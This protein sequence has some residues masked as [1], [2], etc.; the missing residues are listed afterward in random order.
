[1]VVAAKKLNLS[2]LDP[3]A[4]VPVEE[5]CDFLGISRATIYRLDEL[6]RVRLSPGRVGFRVSDLL[7]HARRGIDG[8]P[9]T[10]GLTNIWIADRDGM[11]LP[12]W[13]L[14]LPPMVNTIVRRRPA[15]AR[16]SLAF[17]AELA[18]AKDWCRMGHREL[19]LIDYD[20]L[21]AIEP[22]KVIPQEDELVSSKRQLMVTQVHA[23]VRLTPL[24]GWLE[25]IPDGWWAETKQ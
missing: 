24:F 17:S 7:E 19:V 16:A 18:P 13:F 1:M 10:D 14:L 15:S 20:G 23:V 11:L 4:I 25:K 8:A 12:D 5:A 2:D 3:N 21:N 6:K 22:M 9:Q